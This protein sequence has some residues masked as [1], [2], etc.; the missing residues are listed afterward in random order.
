MTTMTI[1]IA[2]MHCASCKS[3][4][5]DVCKETKGVSSCAVDLVTGKGVIEHDDS[6]DFAAMTA[7]IKKLGEYTVEKI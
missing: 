6:L 5:E 4:I 2:G 1:K 7:E 3:L